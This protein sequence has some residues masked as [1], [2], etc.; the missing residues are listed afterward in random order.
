M[1]APLFPRQVEGEP[2]CSDHLEPTSCSGR[3]MELEMPTHTHT[4]AQLEQMWGSCHY[5]LMSR[6][7]CH[8]VPSISIAE[9]TLVILILSWANQ[10]SRLLCHFVFL[11]F[12][13]FIF[14]NFHMG[15]LAWGFNPALIEEDSLSLSLSFFF[16]FL[17]TPLANGGSWARDQIWA[18]PET[19]TTAVAMLDP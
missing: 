18:A 7:D 14:F 6:L 3:L 5:V 12:C 15:W 17:A 8:R 19:Y 10:S 2:T 1:I 11:N 16:F 4:A 13:S 9:F